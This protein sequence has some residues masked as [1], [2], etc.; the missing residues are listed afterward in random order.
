MVGLALFCWWRCWGVFKCNRLKQLSVFGITQPVFNY[1]SS[2][3]LRN[4]KLQNIYQIKFQTGIF[5]G[6]S[7]AQYYDISVLGY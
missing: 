5:H 7:A 1:S 2:R 3:R 6:F 4:F